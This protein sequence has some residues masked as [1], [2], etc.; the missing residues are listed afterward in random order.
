MQVEYFALLSIALTI[1]AMRKAGRD[2]DKIQKAEYQFSQADLD[3]DETLRKCR[4]IE[5]ELLQ[6]R[7]TG[8][9]SKYKSIPIEWQHLA[10]NGNK[11]E[12]AILLCVEVWGS[13][14]QEF[15]NYR[16]RDLM[17]SPLIYWD[18][19]DFVNGQKSVKI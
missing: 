14:G 5:H 4:R 9:P 19:V 15:Y 13:N 18:V 7:K 10:M 2:C 12:F 11:S 1:L 16:L 3:F 17:A 8:I 6:A